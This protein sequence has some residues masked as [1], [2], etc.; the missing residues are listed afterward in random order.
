MIVN[1]S[2]DVK[3]IELR[4]KAWI[5]QRYLASWEH[6]Y[7][8]II[9]GQ[10]DHTCCCHVG[11]SPWYLWGCWPGKLTGVDV[12]NPPSP[13]LPPAANIKASGMD[14]ENL[15]FVLPND[16]K[17][18]APHRRYTGI[19]RY[20]PE[21]VQLVNLMHEGFRKIVW[22]RSPNQHRAPIDTGMAQCSDMPF[23][24]HGPLPPV[25]RPPR[26]CI[27]WEFDIDYG[28]RCS[29]HIIDKIEVEFEGE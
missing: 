4:I 1:I 13:A 23:P 20:A 16:W 15:I 22:D 12:A 28:P 2:D 19:V 14:G 24:T 5:N 6:I 3:Q 11:G 8:T 27:L 26:P 7:L 10:H 25:I 17:A 9:P 18:H 29:Q 21:E